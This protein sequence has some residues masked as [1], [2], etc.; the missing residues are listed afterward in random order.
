[1]CT[2]HNDGIYDWGW[3]EPEPPHRNGFHRHKISESGALLF[4]LQLYR[5][6]GYAVSAFTT[7]R[8]Y[9]EYCYG[10]LEN[11]VWCRVDILT[12]TTSTTIIFL[13]LDA[14]IRTRGRTILYHNTLWTS[15]RSPMSY[16]Y[17]YV[18]IISI[19]LL[20]NGNN[21]A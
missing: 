5:C 16:H 19:Q 8:D 15:T 18:Y 7:I 17:L 20:L 3:R 13:P 4:S 10:I 14:T 11:I 6:G 21:F 2:F 12:K 1:M 9:D